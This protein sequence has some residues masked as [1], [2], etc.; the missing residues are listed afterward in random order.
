MRAHFYNKMRVGQTQMRPCDT[1]P[2]DT[3]HLL[4]DCPLQ[5]IPRL[6]VWPE[7]TPLREKL[8]GDLVVL[9]KTAS[10][11]QATGMDV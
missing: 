11:V 4:Q 5:D 6:A 8:Y 9:R 3:V 1:A 10:F 7:E 2:M